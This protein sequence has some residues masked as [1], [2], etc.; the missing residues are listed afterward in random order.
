MTL[1]SQGY[2][3]GVLGR[4]PSRLETMMMEASAAGGILYPLEIDYYD[5]EGLSEAVDGAA[6]RFGPIDILVAWMRDDA[7]DSLHRLIDDICDAGRPWKLF[8]VKGSAAAA[9]DGDRRNPDLSQAKE[10]CQYREVLLGFQIENGTSRWLAD[11]EI[12]AGV[13]TAIE[14][15]SPKVVGTVEPW[16]S[17]PSS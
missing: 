16:D 5:E 13:V 1:A 6:Q 8:H 11:D 2:V 15:D 17:R 14:E 9:P 10:L 7:G 4:D 12:C 3:V